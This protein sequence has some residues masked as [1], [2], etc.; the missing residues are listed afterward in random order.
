MAT[1]AMDALA[2]SGV[3]SA[4]ALR[5][6]GTVRVTTPDQRSAA[7][8]VA[9]PSLPLATSSHL[10]MVSGGDEVLAERVV[11]GPGPAPRLVR[12]RLV[13]GS[14]VDLESFVLGWVA[15]VRS[16]AR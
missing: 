6:D 4:C 3:P 13:A 12:D 15:K 9:N 1:L 8:P 10:D 5:A 16:L 11:V 14:D 7:H 2:D